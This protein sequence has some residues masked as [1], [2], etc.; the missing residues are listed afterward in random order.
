MSVGSMGS[1]ALQACD[2]GG[3]GQGREACR[4]AVEDRAAVEGQGTCGARQRQRSSFPGGEA[5]RVHQGQLGA[6]AGEQVGFSGGWRAAV[7][8]DGCLCGC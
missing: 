3:A 1:N 4:P 2:G 7:D 5:G 8:D 6:S